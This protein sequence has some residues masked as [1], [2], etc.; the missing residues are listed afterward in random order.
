MEMDNR[1]SAIDN[2][3]YA[4]GMA[5]MPD[6]A[7]NINLNDLSQKWKDRFAFFD[8]HGAPGTQGYRDAFKALPRRERGKISYNVLAFIFGPFYYLY[9][10]MQRQAMIWF[11]VYFFLVL[12]LLLVAASLPDADTIKALSRGMGLG[13]AYCMAISINYRYYL[14]R[15]GR[16]NGWNPFK[17]SL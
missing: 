12:V 2:N 13:V 4:V 3:P 11:G 10:G 15:T 17:R 1:Q 6:A 5:T 14:K 16:Y 7:G 8:A 9:L